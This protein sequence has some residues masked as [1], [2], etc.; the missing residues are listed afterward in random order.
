MLR[1][2]AKTRK[3]GS[4]VRHA[5][6]IHRLSR[7]PLESDCREAVG[8]YYDEAPLPCLLVVMTPN[9]TINGCFDTEAEYMGQGSPEP[10]FAVAFNPADA[11]EADAA[12]RS[13]TTFIH[14]N[15]ELAQLITEVRPLT[16]KDH[17]NDR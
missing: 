16:E 4:W 17:S 6:E 12:F 7:L 8:S 10:N 13:L 9:D 1:R 11:E 14:L 2:H 3:V 5:L 15:R